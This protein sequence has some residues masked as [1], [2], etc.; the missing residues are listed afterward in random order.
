M[1]GFSWIRIFTRALKVWWILTIA[2]VTAWDSIEDTSWIKAYV[3]IKP[4]LLVIEAILIAGVVYLVY[5][6]YKAKPRIMGF[7]LWRLINAVG[8]KH[9][10]DGM[11]GVT[12]INLMGTDIKYVGIV[13]CLLL[14]TGLPRW[15]MIEEMW[16]RFGT[17][18]WLDGIVRSFAFGFVHMLVGVPLCG[19]LGIAVVGLF[20]T[21]MYFMGGVAL[22]A[23]AHFQYNLILISVLLLGAVVK[24]IRKDV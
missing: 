12:N 17:M 24:T 9:D 14:L 21:Q 6:L 7:G 4:L 15:A 2:Y 22:S 8:G 20:F 3:G 16:F 1:E 13:M 5:A 23:Q 10:E 11:S 19:A 18:G